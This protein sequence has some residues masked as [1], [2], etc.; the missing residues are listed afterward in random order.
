MNLEAPV[1]IRPGSALDPVPPDSAARK[2]WAKRSLAA[3]AAAYFSHYLTELPAPFHAELMSIA[4][5]VALCRGQYASKRGFV[6]AAARGHAKSAIVSTILPAYLTC[7][8]LKSF[9]V[10]FSASEEP[11]AKRHAKNLRDEFECNALLRQDFGELCGGQFGRRWTTTTLDLV[12]TDDSGNVKSTT[13]IMT[14][15]VGGDARGIRN[16]ELRP[17]LL[18][19]DDVESEQNSNTPDSAEKLANWFFGDALPMLDPKIGRALVLGTVVSSSG[20]IE[21]LLAQSKL[22][23]ASF[24]ARRWPAILPDGTPQ[25]PARFSITALAR[26]RDED[27]ATFAREYMLSAQDPSMVHVRPEWLRWWSTDDGQLVY[28]RQQARFFWQGEPCT[29][30][31]FTDPAISV[32]ERASEFAVVIG[33][34]ARDRRTW[35]V[36]DTYHRRGSV[37]E[38]LQEFGRL[39][40]QYHWTRLGVD[41]SA[42]GLVLPQVISSRFRS[43]TTV[44]FRMRKPKADRIGAMS[45]LFADGRVVLRRAAQ[46]ERGNVDATGE[47]RVH[48]SQDALYRQLINFP[49]VAHDDLVDALEGL[50]RMTSGMPLFHNFAQGSP[51]S[52]AM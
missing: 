25:W 26:I 2:A 10:L 40:D 48:P 42:L 52:S 32:K 20:L 19:C 31:A 27:P 33:A 3:F 36:L 37:E 22:P 43:M 35:V 9:I 13:T 4:L 18:L 21:R 50:L 1:S 28:D 24:V 12:Q 39:Y 51:Y 11:Q 47:R 46:G 23:D 45:P 34:V 44:P 38:H 30:Y 16:R 14:R 49:Q 5:D 6:A 17:D 8:R 15:G 41:A 7:Y 29:V